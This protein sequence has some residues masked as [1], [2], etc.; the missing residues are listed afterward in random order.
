MSVKVRGLRSVDLI[1]QFLVYQVGIWAGQG[2]LRN[3]MNKEFSQPSMRKCININGDHTL[4]S[5]AIAIILVPNSWDL[6]IS[7]LE[8]LHLKLNHIS[9]FCNDIFSSTV[10]A[11]VVL[12]LKE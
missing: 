8:N 5:V 6:Q 3:V 9:K 12:I 10:Q 1:S 2:Y 7:C 4:I 11:E